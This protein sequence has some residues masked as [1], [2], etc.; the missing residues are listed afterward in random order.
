MPPLRSYA[1]ILRAAALAGPD[2][3]AVVTVAP[4]GT[5]RTLSRAELDATSD[6]MAAGL[7]RLGVAPR[8]RVAVGLPNG[9]E[10]VLA[11][12]AVWKLGGCVLP[13]DPAA[14]PPERDGHL[15][16]FDPEVVVAHW[17]DLPGTVTGAQLSDSARAVP[18]LPDV[19]ADPG[20]AIGTGGSTGRPK[21]LVN[22]GPWGLT[23]ELA[24]V[25]R[26]FGLAAGDVQLLPGPLYHNFGFDWCYYGLMLGHTVVLLERFDAG[27]AV[28]AIERHRVTTVG[29]VPTMMRR[30]AALDGIRDRDLSSLRE[31]VHSAGPCPAAVKRDWI[32]L[33]GATRVLE[34]YG[35]SEGYGNTVIRGDEWLRHPGSVGRGYHCDIRVLDATGAAL[36]PGEVGEIYMRPHELRPAE[37]LGADPLRTPDGF[38]SV[39][40]LGWLDPDGFLHLADRRVDLVV[41]GGVNVYPAEVEAALADH[42]QVRDAAVIG[43]PDE[44]WGQ[45]VHAVI[46]L[47]AGADEP[48]VG[49][50]TAHCRARLAPYKLP[51]SY[52]F[53]AALPRDDGG[54][55]RRA[56]LV[57]ARVPA[58]AG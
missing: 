17:P 10:H 11:C 12:S 1:A 22:D 30:I 44:E 47:A 40:D 6:V 54:K 23:A 58:A 38:G 8:S 20:K 18:A 46:Q 39:G 35:A 3:P 19:V 33:I 14:P 24:D 2:E 37:Y 16:L 41:S 43:L 5:E 31:I 49:Q 7:A 27:L 21:L 53:V 50:L 28:D 55:L 51:R 4:D 48:T 42:P 52:E 15:A 45:R 29:F 36:P 56:A 57:S 34:A 9:A 13:L 32:E 25:L 26:G